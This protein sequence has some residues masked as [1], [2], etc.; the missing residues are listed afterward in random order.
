[1]CLY[2]T[3][4]KIFNVLFNICLSFELIRSYKRHYFEFRKRKICVHSKMYRQLNL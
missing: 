4:A 2:V 3:F 1:M